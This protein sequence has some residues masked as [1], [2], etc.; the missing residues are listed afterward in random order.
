MSG[1]SI[2]SV[3]FLSVQMPMFCVSCTHQVDVLMHKS[4]GSPQFSLLLYCNL[5]GV[6]MLEHTDGS[7]ELDI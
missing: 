3:Y 7:S 2:S 6:E 1:K 4:N 5:T